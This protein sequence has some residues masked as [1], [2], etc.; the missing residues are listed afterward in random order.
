MEFNED[1]KFVAS[2]RIRYADDEEGGNMRELRLARRLTTGSQMSIHSERSTT[3]MS[4]R[5]SIDP[6]STLPIQYKTL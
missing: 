4:R 5:G 6:A 3:S 2:R 1:E